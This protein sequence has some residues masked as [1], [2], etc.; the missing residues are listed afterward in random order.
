MSTAAVP[1]DR[2]VENLEFL[3][4]WEERFQYIIDLGK[5]LPPMPPDEQ[6]EANRVYGCQATVWMKEHIS[7]HPVLIDINAISDAH[8]VNGLIAILLA[9]YS[10]KSPAEILA[11]DAA[12]FFKKLGL[13]EHL[14]PTRRNG[15]HAMIKRV[16]DIATRHAA[17]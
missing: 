2:I 6:V 14:S 5:K 12:G 11:F 15:L 3:D 10:G 7:A 16:R 17:C 9:C 13:E 8:I 1:L 4:D